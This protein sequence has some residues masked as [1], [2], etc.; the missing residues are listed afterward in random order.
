MCPPGEGLFRS[1]CRI[2]Q[3]PREGAEVTGQLGAQRA[4][5][6]VSRAGRS[7]SCSSGLWNCSSLISRE[8]SQGPCSL[9]GDHRARDRSGS[10]LAELDP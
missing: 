7:H 1:H 8:A 2:W 4:V 6:V 10:E 3:S 5:R 9:H